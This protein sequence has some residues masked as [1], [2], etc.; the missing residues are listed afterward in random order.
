MIIL[1]KPKIIALRTLILPAAIEMIFC[2]QSCDVQI[3][4]I[5]ELEFMMW[6]AKV[7]QMSARF[8][9]HMILWCRCRYD[10]KV[11]Y[12]IYNQGRI[13]CIQFMEMG[14][15]PPDSYNLKFVIMLASA[16]VHKLWQP[17]MYLYIC[18]PVWITLTY[19]FVYVQAW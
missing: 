12:M 7:M 10:H 17:L 11:L 14:P 15:L 13:V 1:L 2:R 6:S 16:C 8:F 19:F 5:Q 9:L 4:Q 18:F 3:C